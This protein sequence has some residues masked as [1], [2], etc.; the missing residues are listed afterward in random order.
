MKAEVKTSNILFSCETS[1]HR[2]AEQ[3]I[4]DHSLV[5]VV[6]GE[7][8]LQFQQMKITMIEGDIVIVRRNEL[9]KA[10]KAPDKNGNP[11]KSVTVALSQELMTQYSIR[12]K[13]Q[14][15]K[16]YEFFP[17]GFFN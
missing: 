7:L 11:Y 17:N 6:S 2:A 1:R 4:A 9:A 10:V 3:L 5:M 13:I 15:Q 12:S 14:N 16:S 8:A